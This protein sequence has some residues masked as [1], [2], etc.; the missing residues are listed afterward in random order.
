MFRTSTPVTAGNFFDR[1]QEIDR[2]EETIRNLKADSPNWLAI[3]GPRKVGKTSLI[4]ELA[5]RAGDLATDTEPKVVFIVMDCFEELPLMPEIF[6]RYALR[7][8]DAALGA[9]LGSSLER[10]AGRPADL[11]AE[12]L[13]SEGLLQVQ[14]KLETSLVKSTVDGVTGAKPTYFF[15]E[16]YM[17][18]YEAEWAAFVDLVAGGGPNPASLDDGVVALAMAEAATRS[19]E[20]GLPVALSDV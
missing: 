15:L 11:R 3:I 13:G 18:A 1:Q 17:P 2:L 7:T 10:L 19:A 12:L 5:R 14:N 9:E 20:T 8:V 16:R 4:L 6:R